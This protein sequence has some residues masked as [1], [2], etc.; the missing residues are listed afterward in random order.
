[1]QYLKYFLSTYI[2]PTLNEVTVSREHIEHVVNKV[3]SLPQVERFLLYGQLIDN[4]ERTKLDAL[5]YYIDMRLWYLP[6]L[7]KY[8]SHMTFTENDDAYYCK[9]ISKMKDGYYFGAYYRLE[10]VFRFTQMMIHYKDFKRGCPNAAK[11][12]EEF[13]KAPYDQYESYIP[14]YSTNVLE[15]INNLKVPPSIVFWKLYQ[16]YGLI[17]EMGI[18]QIL[19]DKSHCNIDPMFIKHNADTIVDI[20]IDTLYT[21]WLPT[22]KEN[23][24]D[25]YIKL[26]YK[27]DRTKLRDMIKPKLMWLVYV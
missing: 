6:N 15:A 9:I 25:R 13:V 8:I 18:I 12:T 26:K 5:E 3:I 11:L 7:I 10:C 22:I 23:H 14:E 1:M 19:F 27:T 4:E 20:I 16:Q 2:E 17:D 24:S 21:K